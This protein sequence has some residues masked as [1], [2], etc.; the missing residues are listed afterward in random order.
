MAQRHQH[1]GLKKEMRAQGET[2]YCSSVLLGQADG[3]RVENKVPIGLVRHLPD[4]SSAWEE[5][6][7]LHVPINRVDMRRAIDSETWLSTTQNTSWLKPPN[8]SAPRRTHNYKRAT[9]EF[10]ETACSHDGGTESHSASSRGS[11]AVAEG[12][13]KGKDILPIR[14]STRLV[15]VHVLGV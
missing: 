6:E 3:K 5:V 8:Q 1:A 2:W 4:A 13:E 10:S 7:R 14:H 9:S 12:L 15:G 11:G